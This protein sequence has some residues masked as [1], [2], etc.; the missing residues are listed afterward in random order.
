MTKR[1]R[2]YIVFG[3]P[4]SGKS[5]IVR[6]LVRQSGCRAID[7]DAINTARGVG[8]AGSAITPE[9]WEISFARALAQLD[10][11]LAAG[12]SV[13]YDG[14]VWSRTQREDFRA[15]TAAAGAD[16]TFIY[17]DVPESVARERWQANRQTA[18][19]HDVPDNLFT[20]AV[21]LMEPPD[22]T[23]SVMRYEG[24]APVAAWVAALP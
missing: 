2:L 10:D 14:H 8:I 22:E 6:E 16:I 24:E 3:I 1:P 7:I 23:E 5:T 13:A 18:Q 20:Q 19:R 21:A 9:D 11:A 17:L 12:E 15:V 4:F